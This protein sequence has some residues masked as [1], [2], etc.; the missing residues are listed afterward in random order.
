MIGED[1]SVKRWVVK[2]VL[3]KLRCACSEAMVSGQ[4]KEKNEG[5]GGC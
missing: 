2:I 1:F 3:P 4:K 5:C